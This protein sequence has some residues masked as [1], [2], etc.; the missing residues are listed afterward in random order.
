MT[1][2]PA[3]PGLSVW[4][5][6]FAFIL[7]IFGLAMTGGGG[8]LAAVGGSWYYLLAGLGSIIAAI[9][10]FRRSSSAVYWFGLVFVGTLLWTIYE[11]GLDYWGWV[12]RFDIMLLL[13]IAFAFQLPNLKPGIS[14][15]FSRSLGAVFIAGFV[16]AAII[17]FTALNV[18][19]A[20]DVPTAGS[21]SF[22]TDTGSGKASNPDSGDWYTYGGSLA[23]QRFVNSTQITPENVK[24]LKLA[25]QFRTGDLPKT[26]WGAENTPIKVGDTLYTC[27]ARNRVFA[28]DAATGKEKWHFDPKVDDKSIPYT[29]ACRGLTWFDA[30]TN[31]HVTANQAT[32]AAPVEASVATS[33]N[34]DCDQRI[35]L[36]T[37]DARIIE[38]NAKTGE[39][40]RS[41]GH[42]GTV[43]LTEDMG[44]VYEGYVA[45]NSA[46]VV[47]RDTLVV[48]HQTIDGQRAFGPPGVIKAYDVRTGELKW[49]WDAAAPNTATPKSGPDAYK[50]GSPDVWTSFT[51]DDKLGLVYLPVANASGDY[52]SS[53]RTAAE[54]KYAVTLTALDIKTGLP[55]WSF[56]SAHKDVWDY[57]PGSQPT[58][59]DYPAKNGEKIPAII[60][61]TKQG[62]IYVLDRRT[63]K[64][65][66]GVEE[67]NVPGGGVE[68]EARSPTQPYSLFHHLSKPDLTPKDMW[69]LTPFDQMVCR[70]Q[71]QKASYKGQYTPPESS[72]HSI[73]YPG[74]NG[75]S[76][77]GS[78]AFDPNRGIIIANY[79]DMPN[80]N[81]LV[82]RAKADALGWK[83][84]DEIDAN[85]N[86]KG[87]AEGAGDPQ[88]GVPYAV[89][90]NAG[91][92]LPFTGMLCKEPPYGGIRAIDVR[93]GRTLW[94]RPL[95]TARRNGPFGLPSGLP[96]NIGTPNNGGSV[97]TSS[98]LIFIAAATDDLIRAIDI[99]TG[100]TVW[101]TPLP[102]GGQ[103]N[104]MIY[105]QNGREYLV[106]VAA[107]HH[108]METPVGDYVLAWALP[109]KQ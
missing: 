98:G 48:A 70:I 42:E 18:T 52:W 80:Y 10:I 55:V 68:P 101:S 72:R 69:G 34:G 94:D 102:A 104:P 59:F 108:F 15:T 51:G 26:R 64:S 17:P 91:W 30:T 13:G 75:G 58:L 6:I 66:F 79:N 60:Y 83:P 67:R 5:K 33:D 63:G 57:D 35:I 19:P 23:S 81:I 61:P 103:A 85:P 36:G 32:A 82:P 88:T 8:Y 40:C 76:D 37:L 14:R 41:F 28:L 38:L 44:E 93:D 105:T 100:K 84:R 56:Q 39:V 95:G 3:Y 27:T 78:V 20:K 92:R 21:N 29:A 77:W 107:G 7:L 74:Y 16:V 71:F 73:E 87:H 4:N 2:T 53:S 25:W 96:I 90:V 24:D 47:I 54:L 9:A 62:E 86:D 49:A 22:A 46:P 109:E 106:I 12:P 89:N 31:S 45:I 65:L 50:R 99:N 11:S 1:T 97:V 43:K